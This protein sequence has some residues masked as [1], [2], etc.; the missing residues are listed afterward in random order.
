MVKKIKK[1]D[2][3]KEKNMKEKDLFSLVVVNDKQIN[4]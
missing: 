4:S 2:I 3:V 1:K